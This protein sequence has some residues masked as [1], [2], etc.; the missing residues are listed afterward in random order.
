MKRLV[1][2]LTSAAVFCLVVA[3]PALAGYGTPPGGETGTRGDDP[4][5]TAF[6]GTNVSL[7]V[8]ILA[9]LIVIGITALLMSRRRAAAVASE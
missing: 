2:A 7:G 5:G 4:A 9:V 3:A 6:T 1:F 8:A